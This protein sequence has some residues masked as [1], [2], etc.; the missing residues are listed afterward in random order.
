[1][2]VERKGTRLVPTIMPCEA[3]RKSKARYPIKATPFELLAKAKRVKASVG[4]WPHGEISSAIH[5]E[6]YSIRWRCSDGKRVEHLGARVAQWYPD[7]SSFSSSAEDFLLE[8][9]VRIP[10]QMFSLIHA[11]RWGSVAF[12]PQSGRLDA[13]G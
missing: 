12:A 1:V 11:A 3:P 2:S 6:P 9:W 7:G 10:S 5:R 8:P 4:H 13:T